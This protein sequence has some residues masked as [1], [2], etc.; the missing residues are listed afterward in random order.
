MPISENQLASF[1]M[2]TSTRNIIDEVGGEI[3]KRFDLE[4][5]K[6]IEIWDNMVYRA[7]PV[8]C[9]ADRAL[10]EYRKWC[11]QFYSESSMKVIKSKA[12]A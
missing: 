10:A 3:I 7:K 6:D 5:P 8:L 1:V 9:K 12:I 4:I 2:L 11:R